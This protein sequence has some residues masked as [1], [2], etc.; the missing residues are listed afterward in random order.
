MF[1]LFIPV[2]QSIKEKHEFSIFICDFPRFVDSNSYQKLEQ[3]K[4]HVWWMKMLMKSTAT[5]TRWYVAK[6]S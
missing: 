1:R 6:G 4:S 2:Y 3:T 5:A